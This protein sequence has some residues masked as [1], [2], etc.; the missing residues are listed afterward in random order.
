MPVKDLYYQKY[1]KYKN[2]YLNLHSQIGG[3]G[4]SIDIKDETI[5]ID[6][7][8]ETSDFS[9]EELNNPNITTIKLNNV[10]KYYNII[11]PILQEA[12]PFT[13]IT[14]LIFDD[15]D[16]SNDTNIDLIVTLIK[17]FNNVN[18][19]HF[20][21]CQLN[22]DSSEYLL[23]QLF[24]L[25]QKF[26]IINLDNNLRLTDYEKKTLCSKVTHKQPPFF[27][28]EKDRLEY[29]EKL[30]LQ[31]EKSMNN[32]RL[33]PSLDKPLEIPIDDIQVDL[34]TYRAI[35]D[36]LPEKDDTSYLSVEQKKKKIQNNSSYLFKKSQIQNVDK[37]KDTEYR[38][39]VD[40]IPDKLDT[41]FLSVK[42]KKNFFQ[43]QL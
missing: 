36:T 3:G 16:L 42:Q 34:T 30:K 24:Y 21:N 26:I 6:Y 2:K 10:M 43:D 31:M 14:T 7:T 8:E 23:R 39:I 18:T 20:K 27:W 28:D 19:L 37:K 40:T 1:L 41:S 38:D 9:V 35:T 11:V 13:H 32:Q 22:K 29:D 25:K 5:T 17:L 12:S 33:S 15:N 4:Y